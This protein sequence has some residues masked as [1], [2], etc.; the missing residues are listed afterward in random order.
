MGLFELFQAYT[1]PFKGSKLHYKWAILSVI[2]ATMERR[3]WFPLGGLGQLYPNMYIILCGAAG[4]GKT[5][6]GNVATRFLHDYNES[7]GPSNGGIKFGP[8]KATPA[9]LIK[10]F[11]KSTKVVADL[12]K[13]PSMSCLFV[14]STEAS[15]FLTD[16]GGG[17]LTHDMLKLYDC[18]RQFKKELSGE[19][20]ITI[21]G[22]CLNFLASTTPSWLSNFVQRDASANGFVSRIM[23]AT[24][25]GF[26]EMDD[27]IA[28]GDPALEEGIIGHI[29]RIHRMAGQFKETDAARQFYKEWF[30][31]HRRQL[32]TFIDG[33]FLREFYARKH[34]HMRKIA[35]ALSASRSSDLVIQA[36]DYERALALIEDLEPNMASSF[37]VQDY[38]R[39]PDFSKQLLLLVPTGT[40]ITKAELLR[41]LFNSGL[42]GAMQ[43]FENNMTMLVNAQL[44]TERRDKQNPTVIHYRR[45]QHG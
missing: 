32:Y 30:Q 29:G 15:T 16:I 10:R 31:R 25:V 12:P 28:P 22:P 37:G 39:T 20:I 43:D 21:K 11:S 3:C 6:S 41:A 19:G 17:E 13:R 42:G 23:F 2:G 5:T 24:E 35:M 45:A 44:V 4:C 1:A 40:E 18:D 34:A 26:V 7:L 36:E 14:Y 33:S 27:E 38:R 8:D 9:A